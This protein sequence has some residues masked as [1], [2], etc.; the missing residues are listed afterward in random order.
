MRRLLVSAILALGL[1]TMTVGCASGGAPVSESTPAPPLAEAATGPTITG[2]GYSYSVP[3]GWAEPTEPIPGFDPD[4]LAFDE[5]DADG[6]SDNVNVILSPSGEVTTEQVETLGVDELENAG[7]SDVTV[8]DRVQIAGAESAHL[9][10][11]TSSGE[12]EYLID[13]FYPTHDG[14]TYVVTF[15][16]SPTV[17][18]ADRDEV[19][20]SVLASWA[21][22]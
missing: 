15:S 9:A 4:S 17:T 5:A 22:L 11:G 21:W 8:L 13:Q 19:T 3:E 2:D 16:F 1:V 6:F 18:Q 7:A 20:S 12:I 14:Q 10:A